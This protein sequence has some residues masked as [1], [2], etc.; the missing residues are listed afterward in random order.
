MKVNNKKGRKNIVVKFFFLISTMAL[1]VWGSIKVCYIGYVIVDTQLDLF[2]IKKDIKGWAKVINTLHDELKVKE[3]DRPEVAK[4]DKKLIKDTEK[5]IEERQKEKSK[6]IKSK[7]TVTAYAARKGASVL[8]L[9]LGITIITLTAII[10]FVFFYHFHFK[11]IVKT[12]MLILR[13]VFIILANFFLYANSFFVFI[14]KK[15]QY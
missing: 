15:L 2:D 10:W 3:T 14:Y 13:Y 7:D 6:I 9:L 11:L 4:I 12:E 8:M 1:M 5:K